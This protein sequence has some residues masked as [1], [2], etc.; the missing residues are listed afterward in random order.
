MGIKYVHI[1]GGIMKKTLILFTLLLSS[2]SAYAQS[3]FL[4][5]CKT[6]TAEQIEETL[7]D[8]DHP[9]QFVKATKLD[10]M[11]AHLK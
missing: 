3:S 5:L 6:G 7:K 4:E 8:R 2:L 11:F 1:Y 10:N 9:A